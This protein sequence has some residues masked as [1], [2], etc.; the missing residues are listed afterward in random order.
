MHPPGTEGKLLPGGLLWR[1]ADST[2]GAL[3]SESIPVV[4][5]A[6]QPGAIH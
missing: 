3:R 5:G 4:E 1:W 2:A 6:G